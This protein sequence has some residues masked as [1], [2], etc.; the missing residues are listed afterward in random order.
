LTQEY[1]DHVR[2]PSE[3]RV[4][5]KTGEISVINLREKTV[6]LTGASGDIGAETARVL[7]EAGA[8]VIAHYVND[9]DGAERATA[10]IPPERK[11]LVRCDFAIAGSSR[12]LWAEAIA[13]RGRVDTLVNNAAIMPETPLDASD[14]DWDAEWARAFQINVLEPA[15][16]TREAVRHYIEMDGGVIITMSSWAAQQGSTIPQLTAYASTKA[17]IKSLT[18]TIARAHA[19]DGVLA[20][21]IA[22]GIVRT[23]M[24]QISAT[25]RGGE[26]ALKAILP[27]GDMVP[28]AEVGNL[29][30]FLASGLCRHLSGSTLDINGAAY[31]R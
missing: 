27:L 28:P 22:P 8:H 23:R 13:W 5:F 4:N 21:V 2:T 3:H 15:N 1:C 16:L 12:Q 18:Q 26:D 24:S 10:A 20:Y 7:G 31:V 19:K 9:R 29:V 6:L 11:L 17:A 30:A 14:A 25:S